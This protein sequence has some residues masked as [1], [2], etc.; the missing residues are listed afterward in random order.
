MTNGWT[1]ERRARQSALILNWQP[2]AHSSGQ[3]TKRGKAT[4]ARNARRH[5]MRSRIV[6]EETRLLRELIRQCPDTAQGIRTQERGVKGPPAAV[7]LEYGQVWRGRPIMSAPSA[8][9]RR[10]GGPADGTSSSASP[11]APAVR[12]TSV[13]P[14]S[15]NRNTRATG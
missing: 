9:P 1:T 8:S 11:L 3:K 14:C 12:S 7:R 6:L 4:S 2:W 15:R 5:G 13:A 10:A